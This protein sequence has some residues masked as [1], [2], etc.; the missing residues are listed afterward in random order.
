MAIEQYQNNYTTT[1]T[2]LIDSDDATIPV[3]AAPPDVTGNFRIRIDDELILV[4]AVSGLNFTGCTRGVEGTTAASHDAGVSVYAIIT[5]GSLQDM[6]NT[7]LPATI[8]YI[9]DGS[10]VVITA[11]VKAYIEV[12]FD[13]V[14]TAVR[15]FADVTGSMVIDVWKDTYANYPPVNA[16]SITASANPTISSGVKSQDTTLTGWNKVINAGDILGINVDS[17]TTATLAT[18]SIDVVRT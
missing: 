12:P 7:F 16:D 17:C 14:I 15:M 13:C 4:G 9:I 1:T 18:I 3:T 2:A 11:G 8:E 10:G 6:Q 5:A